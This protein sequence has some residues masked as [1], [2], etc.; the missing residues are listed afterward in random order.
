MFGRAVGAGWCRRRFVADS[1]PPGTG[2]ALRSRLLSAV[3]HPIAGC[4]TLARVPITPSQCTHAHTR[5]CVHCRGP[6]HQHRSPRL[7]CAQCTVSRPTRAASPPPACAA[8]ARPPPHT[9]SVQR[10]PRGPRL[11]CCAWAGGGAAPGPVSPACRL[12]SHPRALA[13][14]FP[15]ALSRPVQTDRSRGLND[16]EVEERQAMYGFNELTEKKVRE[17]GWV[18]KWV[19]LAG[20]R[21]GV[22]GSDGGRSEGWLLGVRGALAGR[23]HGAAAAPGAW[24]YPTWLAP[25]AGVG[26]SVVET[27][28]A[29]CALTPLPALAARACVPVVCVPWRAGEPHPE[30]PVVLLGPH[31]HHGASRARVCLPP[32]LLA[33]LLGTGRA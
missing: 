13:L 17:G 29:Q 16:H 22:G 21:W 23:G 27:G 1:A 18:G 3:G 30:V 8:P 20:G 7:P 33:P 28:S 4:P 32:P 19:G 10:G 9:R 12:A 15:R 25:L 26:V 11:A 2:P 6:P 14:P 31:A 24:M 5:A